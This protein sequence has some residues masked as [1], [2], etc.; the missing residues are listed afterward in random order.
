MRLGIEHAGDHLTTKREQPAVGATIGRWAGS[1]AAIRRYL[2]IELAPVSHLERAVC[3]AGGIIGIF[4]LMASEREFLGETGAAWVVAS[5]GSS[6]VLLYAVPHGALSQPWAVIVGHVVSALVGVTCA[7]LV[8]DLT[9]AAGLAVG[10][11][12]GAMHYLRAIHPPGGATAMT[13]VVAGSQVHDLGYQ[14]VL[15]PVLANSAIMVAIAIAFN[16]AF[17]W[18]RYPAALGKSRTASGASGG[19][20][21]QISH[22]DFMSAL[23]RIGTFIDIDEDDFLRLQQLTQEAADSRRIKV[24]SIRLGGYYSNGAFG[25]DW[26]VRMIVDE[27]ASGNGDVIWRCVAGRDRNK[28][29]HCSRPDFQS[30]AAYEVVR[31][32]S[33]WVRPAESSRD[34]EQAR[35]DHSMRV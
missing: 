27:D 31:S 10:L 7:K 32:E 9:L 1:L 34:G 2:G 22:A 25:A 8:P 13:A 26:A 4:V 12:I 28:T 15:T 24:E 11:A 17:H 6:A 35:H 21:Q 29:G 19:A 18:R 33:A 30:W 20:A 23:Q 5:M 14:F 16:A 3:T